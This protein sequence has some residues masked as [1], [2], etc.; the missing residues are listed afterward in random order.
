M[1]RFFYND[2]KIIKHI[3]YLLKDSYGHYRQILMNLFYLRQF[4]LF[5]IY[6]TNEFMKLCSSI[7][8]KIHKFTDFTH[9]NIN[10]IETMISSRQIILDQKLYDLI[11]ELENDMT[12]Y[13]NDK[14]KSF[15]YHYYSLIY[16][17]YKLKY[18]YLAFDQKLLEKST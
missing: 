8:N 18:D 14:F 15:A 5:P 2:S 17:K 4:I 13:L 12:K 6:D 16:K 10:I 3:A 7:M 11:D 9:K 1:A